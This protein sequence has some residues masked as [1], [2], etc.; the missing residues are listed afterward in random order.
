MRKMDHIFVSI[1]LSMQ[2]ALERMISDF[3]ESLK[4]VSYQLQKCLSKYIKS[5]FFSPWIQS[6]MTYPPSRYL[7]PTIIIEALL[8]IM[9]EMILYPYHQEHLPYLV[10]SHSNHKIVKSSRFL[11]S[12]WSSWSWFHSWL[13]GINMRA[14]R[15][16]DT[17]RT[18]INIWGMS[19][20]EGNHN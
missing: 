9:A 15:N 13:S 18:S 12:S 2:Q 19:L 3:K 6:S 8:L 16:S 4:T 11:L 7:I 20:Q 10:Q 14:W 17:W 5:I 1:G